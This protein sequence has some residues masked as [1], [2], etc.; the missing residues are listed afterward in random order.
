MGMLEISPQRRAA[1]GKLSNL[2]A[3]TNSRSLVWKDIMSVTYC[4]AFLAF[5][6]WV[7]RSRTG[8]LRDWIL[9]ETDLS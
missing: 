1:R 7:S 4:K 8:V 9:W 5:V 2:N 6:L 3:E